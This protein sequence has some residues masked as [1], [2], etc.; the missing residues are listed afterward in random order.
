LT[1]GLA[2]AIQGTA[3]AFPARALPLLIEDTEM[4]LSTQA[5]S[6]FGKCFHLLHNCK[7]S[8]KY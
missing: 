4:G 5:A 2:A 7:N 1:A 8:S 6:W 3:Y